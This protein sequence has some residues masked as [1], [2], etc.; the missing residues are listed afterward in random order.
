MSARCHKTNTEIIHVEDF[1]RAPPR[2]PSSGE[3]GLTGPLGS[4][5]GELFSVWQVLVRKGNISVSR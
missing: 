2:T 5:D 4:L 1:M 3:C